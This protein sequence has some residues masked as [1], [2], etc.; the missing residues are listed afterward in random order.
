MRMALAVVFM[1]FLGQT[2]VAESPAYSRG[3]TGIK[4]LCFDG[5][6]CPSAEV[7]SP[8]H[9]TDFRLI[10][11]DHERAVYAFSRSGAAPG[12]LWRV[13]GDDW[14]D[15]DVLWAP[16]SRFVALSGNT[17]G[18]SNSVRVYQV[19]ES[20]ATAFDVARAPF[21]DMLRTFSPCKAENADPSFC[22]TLTSADDFNFAAVAWKDPNT[23]VLMGEIPCEGTYGGVM[24][25]VM[26]YEVDVPSGKILQRMTAA[27]FKHDW[28]RSMAW[29][30]RVPE[31]P[32]WQK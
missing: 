31:P 2:A 12:Q 26:G 7:P 15:V 6:K 5:Q 9:S 11:D 28:Q 25:Q 10:R 19:T 20:G 30:F 17:S 1:S 21:E 23:I 18:M 29:K 4:V 13:S 8:D 22:R 16:G 14:V 27:E 32:A 24:C 3:A